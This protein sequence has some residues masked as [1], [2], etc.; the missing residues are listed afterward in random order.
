MHRPAT[1]RTTKR[2]AL[3]CARIGQ[4]TEG[5]VELAFEMSALVV[6]RG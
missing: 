1:L 5:T 2:R 4:R 6:L 3:L